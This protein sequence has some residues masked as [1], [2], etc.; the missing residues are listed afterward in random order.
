MN[1]N[2]KSKIKNQKGFTLVE[3]LVVIFIVAIL[4]AATLAAIRQGNK[5]S[6]VLRAAQRVAQDL[7]DAQNRAL[8]AV[9]FQGK[10]PCGWGIEFVRNQNYYLLLTAV[11]LRM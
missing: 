8:A 6:S 10:V 11:H 5:R 1:K 7:R 2:Q 9:E 3:M 4:S